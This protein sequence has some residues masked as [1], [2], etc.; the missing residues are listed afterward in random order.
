M[1]QSQKMRGDKNNIKMTKGNH[2]TAMDPVVPMPK[3]A[4]HAGYFI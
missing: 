3:G 4:L 1:Q 2:K